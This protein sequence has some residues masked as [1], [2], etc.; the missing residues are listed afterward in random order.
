MDSVKIGAAYDEIADH[1]F[2]SKSMYDD[3]VALAPGCAGKILDIGCGQGRFLERLPQCERW[4]C[5]LSPKL[6]AMARA[7]VPTADIRVADALTLPYPDAAFDWVFMVASLE[8]VVDHALALREAV[9]VLKPGG[10]LVIA[11]PNRA[12]LRYER[13]LEC[14]TAFQPVDDYFFMPD[15]LI[16]LIEAAGA[17]VERVRGVWAIVWSDWRHRL[18]MM[19]AAIYPPL[20]RRMKC[21]GVSAIKPATGTA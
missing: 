10:R 5:D 20:H 18:E 1:V 21:I 8:H 4:G 19:A 17:R 13:W 16:G 14:R 15:E 9:R 6:V 2:E 7:R 12:W 11:V 3:V